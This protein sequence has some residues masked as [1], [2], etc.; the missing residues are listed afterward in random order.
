MRIINSTK[1][2]F[3]LF[4]NPEHHN[5]SWN[6]N[7]A[8]K[9]SSFPLLWLHGFMGSSHDWQNFVTEG[10]SDYC[11]ILVDLPGHGN[12]SIEEGSHYEDLLNDLCS[13]LS[14]A[15]FDTFIPVG[16]SMGG[17]L[18][19]HLQR[20]CT[21]QITAIVGI[22]SAPGLKSESERI[23]RMAADRELMTKLRSQGL[24]RFLREW[25]AMPLFQHIGKDRPLLEALIHSRAQND[26][27]QLGRSLELLGNGALPSLW[28]ELSKIEL[29]V[30][31]LTG[32]ADQKYCALNQEMA[33]ELPN[34][35]HHVIIDADHALHLEKPLETTDL[36]RHFLRRVIKGD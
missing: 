20:C 36:I 24:E 3:K 28:G 12:A 27:V 30:L 25:Y 21:D 34:A 4:V 2:Y 22:S 8:G 5:P 16:Y 32:E 18:A 31:L 35:E 23:K 29:P 33:G 14:A 10:F 9:V 17:R 7:F 6:L 26:P 1:K 11:N 19:F 15:G 13:Q